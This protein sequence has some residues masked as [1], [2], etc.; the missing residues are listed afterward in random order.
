MKSAR[1]LSF[2][3]ERAERTLVQYLAIFILIANISIEQKPSVI[4]MRKAAG[5]LVVYAYKLPL[6]SLS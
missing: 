1:K 3:R 2:I 5:E 4:I 6:A